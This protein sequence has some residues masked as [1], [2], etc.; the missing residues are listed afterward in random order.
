MAV[1]GIVGLQLCWFIQ[2]GMDCLHLRGKASLKLG[3]VSAAL[4]LT[5]AFL[6][7]SPAYGLGAVAWNL[8]AG[9]LAAY[10]G[11]RNENTARIATEFRGLRR[12]MRKAGRNELQRILSSNRNYYFELAPYALVLGLD[13]PFAAKFGNARLPACTWL[14]SKHSTRTAPE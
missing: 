8:L 13:K 14:V 12:H 3:L 4:L 11:R 5:A 7:S 9:L 6:C 1:L 2:S 10:G